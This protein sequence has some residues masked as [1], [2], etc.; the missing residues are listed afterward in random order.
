MMQPRFSNRP[1]REVGECHQVDLAAGNVDVVPLPEPPERVRG[2]LQGEPGQVA[3][4]GWVDHPHRCSVDVDRVGGLKWP[5]DEGNEVGGE[6]DRLFE[7]H[8]VCSV[9]EGGPG[10]LCSVGDSQQVLWSHQGHGEGGLHVGFVKAREGPPGVGRLE[11]RGGNGVGGAVGV[12]QGAVVET[13]QAVV[14]GTGEVQVEDGIPAVGSPL[15]NEGDA[16]VVDVDVD[17]DNDVHVPG[18]GRVGDGRPAHRQAHRVED[19]S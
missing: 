4:S 2:H 3:P 9:A 10:Q 1:E 8:Q 7:H 5:H 17:V 18:T 13:P 15:W 16:F 11:L 14:E 12:R 6:R 19:D